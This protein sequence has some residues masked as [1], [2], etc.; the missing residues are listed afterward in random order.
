MMNAEPIRQRILIVDD[1]PNNIRALA[2][3]FDN[4]YHILFAT[5]GK[6]ALR[7]AMQEKPDVMLLD[8][9]MPEM[10]GYQV[11]RL[12]KSD[13]LTRDI[14]IIFITIKS[15]TDHEILGLEMGA[16][17]YIC[18]PFCAAIVKLRVSYQIELKCARE[19]LLQLAMTDGLTGVANR[20]KFDEQLTQ[21]WQRATRMRQYLSVVMIDV[22]WFKNYNDYYGHQAGDDCL[23]EVAN[24]LIRSVKRSSDLVAR[25]GGEEFGL[26][27]PM[28]DGKVALKIANALCR[29]LRELNLLHAESNIGRLTLS[30]GVAVEIP[31]KNKTAEKLV[32]HADLALYTAKNQGRNQAVLYEPTNN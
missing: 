23:R 20:R 6:Q 28:T 15:H 11:C 16:A 29:S 12:M 25:Y 3:I 4:E 5:D 2:A 14:P 22:D 10:D 18:K 8:V 24:L 1:D 26:I 27:L 13:H 31:S 7:V 9:M 19:K 30:A 32:Q 21:E 17:D